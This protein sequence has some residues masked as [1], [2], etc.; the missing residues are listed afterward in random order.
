MQKSLIYNAV[1]IFALI[2][3][4]E[5]IQFNFSGNS[6]SVTREVIEND[7]PNYFEIIEN[8]QINETQF[9]EYLENKM[10]DNQFV[11]EIYQDIFESD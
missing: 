11:E 6:Y 2:D 10:N 4:V 8:N 9:N 1:S 3:N 5:Y 7:Y